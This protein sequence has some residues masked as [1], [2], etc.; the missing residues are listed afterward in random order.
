[1]FPA[2]FSPK[3]M[4]RSEESGGDVSVI[5]LAVPAHWP[6]P[7]LHRH[8]F[9]EGFHL[10]EGELTFQVEEELVSARAGEFVFAPGGVAHTVANLSDAPAS[11]LLIC[12][13]A[14]FER[15]FAKIAAEHAGEDPPTWALQDVPEVERLGPQIGERS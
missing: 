11:Y 1:M 5:K 10:L 7:P 13:P 15:Y 2:S 14:G 8:D 4:L 3:V 9:A 12:T 6:G